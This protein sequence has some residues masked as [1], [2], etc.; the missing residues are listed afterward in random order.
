MK[1]ISAVSTK[2]TL[3][4]HSA[5]NA[6]IADNH[7]D[8][9]FKKEQVEDADNEDDSGTTS[10]GNSTIANPKLEEALESGNI[11]NLGTILEQPEI[12]YQSDS[13]DTEL[14]LPR[15]GQKKSQSLSDEKLAGESLATVLEEGDA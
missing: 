13:S 8:F 12:G 5:S 3:S 11:G 9:D 6:S 2:S 15:C 4:V 14:L 10:T 7:F 1:P